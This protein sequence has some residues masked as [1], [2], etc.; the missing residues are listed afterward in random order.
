MLNQC[1]IE[2]KSDYQ[3]EVDLGKIFSILGKSK[4]TIEMLKKLNGEVELQKTRAAN[5]KEKLN[6]LV[7]EGKPLVQQRD[8]LK[9]VI[10]EKTNKLDK[11]L[12]ELQEK[13]T[14]LGAA[15]SLKESL[16]QRDVNYLAEDRLELDKC[17]NKIEN[18][19]E[20]HILKDQNGSLQVDLQRY[21]DKAA[22]LREKLF[23]VVKKGKDPVEKAKWCATYLNEC[24]LEIVKVERV[25]DLKDKADEAGKLASQLQ[26][27]IVAT[28]EV[29]IPADVTEPLEKVMWCATYI[30]ECQVVKAKKNCEKKWEEVSTHAINLNEARK[31]IK[32][33]ED[34]T[35][36]L[37][38]QVSQFSNTEADLQ[39]TKVVLGN[40]LRKKK[41]S[42]PLWG[43]PTW[44]PG[45]E[46][47][48]EKKQCLQEVRNKKA[49]GRMQLEILKLLV[50]VQENILGIFFAWRERGKDL[51]FESLL[52]L[53]EMEGEDV[54]KRG[55]Y[56]RF[57]DED[58]EYKDKDE[59]KG[60]IWDFKFRPRDMSNSEE[61]RHTDNTTLVPPRLPDTL[62]QVY[63]RRRPTLGLLILP[64]VSPFLPTIRRTARISFLPIKPNLAERARISA[65]NLDDYQL[66]PLTL[67]PSPSS[68][69]SMATYQRMTAGTDPT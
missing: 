16:L 24:Q 39:C 36:Q 8:S 59:I 29:A 6:L 38:T 68:P 10:V 21:E 19:S 13:S 2:V 50:R 3:V 27:M 42:Q 47:R 25:G 32:S 37:Q 62:P 65:I 54:K 14:A 60:L 1:L 34:A 15:D 44:E 41:L 30:H 45:L 20:E 28:D 9:Q 17:S 57:E 53:F 40:N 35:S 26:R 4:E 56:D 11:C 52:I 51:K 49:R 63:H 61:L 31:S 22:L 12:I 43:G 7:T 66:D 23:M 58:E 18:L 69:F 46:R 67:P 48:K 33:L 64:L 5:T 55:K